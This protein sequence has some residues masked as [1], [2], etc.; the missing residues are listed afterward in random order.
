MLKGT[1]QGQIMPLG[2]QLPVTA[3]QPPKGP[4]ALH[5]IENH[6]CITIRQA[7][8]IYCTR[9]QYTG[10]QKR[11]SQCTGDAATVEVW[12]EPL[13]LH[14]PGHIHAGAFHQLAAGIQKQALG[15]LRI[16]PFLARHDVFK[17]A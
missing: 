14:T 15:Y 13:P 8:S 4:D 10:I 2:K 6:N 17:P 1:V 9:G 5:R 3:H 16:H 12:R 11:C 7:S